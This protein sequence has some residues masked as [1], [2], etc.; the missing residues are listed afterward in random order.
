MAPKVEYAWKPNAHVA[1][2]AK[3]V[4]P[5]L[6]KLRKRSGG[7]LSPE[8][9]LAA[10]QSP[11]SPIHEYFEWDDDEAATQ[12][13]LQQ[14]RHLITVIVVSRMEEPEPHRAFVSVTQGDK[15][16]ESSEEVKAQ[17]ETDGEK[18]R[19]MLSSAIKSYEA[20]N[21]RWRFYEFEELDPVVEAVEKVAAEVGLLVEEAVDA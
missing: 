17:I 15:K 7:A 14:A 2:D 3:V 18:R 13:R 5:F 1:L 10:A 9:V 6:E 8:A 4:G 19:T 21:R 12:Y 11:D 16:Y 20:V